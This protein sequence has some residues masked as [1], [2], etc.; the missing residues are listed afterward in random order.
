MLHNLTHAT[1]FNGCGKWNNAPVEPRTSPAPYL[2]LL[3]HVYTTPKFKRI[4]YPL[5]FAMGKQKRE[6]SFKIFFSSQE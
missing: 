5:G 2:K 1:R 6:I 4:S 3:F